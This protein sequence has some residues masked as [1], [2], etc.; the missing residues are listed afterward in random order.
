MS[1][2]IDLEALKKTPLEPQ[3]IQRI[4]G[5]IDLTYL[6]EDDDEA[7]A[8]LCRKAKNVAA[9][10]VYPQYI[11]RAKQWAA[12]PHT[13]IATVVNFPGGDQ[14][15]NT[16]L[17]ETERCLA[18]GVDEID[19]VLPYQDFLS[20]HFHVVHQFL[21]AVR[22]HSME[23][24]LKVI[25]ESGALIKPALIRLAGQ[26]VIDCG[27]DFIKTSTGKIPVGATLE[28]AEILLTLIDQTQNRH[29]GLKISGGVRSV[30]D[31]H[32]YLYLTRAIM[33]DHWIN[34]NT[35][36]FGASQLL[37]DLARFE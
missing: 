10:C 23:G 5:L 32:A 11:E 1:N 37:D 33:G 30:E 26:M 16:V 17:A 12:T 8:T 9:I 14:D 13:K 24:S 35:F 15:L 19:L 4:R 2:T 29:V 34:P 7:V 18:L 28:T 27:A 21:A 31:A 25:I 3:L 36:R 22:K 6:G 20:G